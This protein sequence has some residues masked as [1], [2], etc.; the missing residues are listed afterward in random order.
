MEFIDIFLRK[1][2]KIS[3]KLCFHRFNTESMFVKENAIEPD[4]IKSE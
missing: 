2:F 1:G 3:L 4:S